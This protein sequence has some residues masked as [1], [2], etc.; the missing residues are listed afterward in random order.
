MGPLLQPWYQ[1]KSVNLEH[2]LPLDETIFSPALAQEIADSLDELI[3][4][5]RYFAA[6]CAAV[7]RAE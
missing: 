7:Y 3:P 1:K 2:T 6:L 4:F 5:Y